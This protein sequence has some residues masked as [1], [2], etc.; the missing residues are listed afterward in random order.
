MVAEIARFVARAIPGRDPFPAIKAWQR[1]IHSVAVH[2]AI[3]LSA[4]E[5]RWG[6]FRKGPRGSAPV[7][8]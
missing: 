7:S 6:L 1:M 4:R 5:G 8:L 3:E 2:Q